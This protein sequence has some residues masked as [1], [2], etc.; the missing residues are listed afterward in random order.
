MSIKE[1]FL[2]IFMSTV[3]SFV[4]FNLIASSYASLLN[5]AIE[6]RY[7]ITRSCLAKGEVNSHQSP[8]HDVRTLQFTP[9]KP[10]CSN[11]K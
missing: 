10:D 9:F 4:G 6:A 8:N 1:K 2:I 7:D 5:G 3:A 11:S